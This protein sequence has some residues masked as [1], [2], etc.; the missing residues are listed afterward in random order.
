MYDLYY[1]HNVV[2]LH[3]GKGDEETQV[4]LKT[5]LMAQNRIH[6]RGGLKTFNNWQQTW[7]RTLHK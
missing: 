6:I 5:T 4:A 2:T 1:M 7:G 3:M